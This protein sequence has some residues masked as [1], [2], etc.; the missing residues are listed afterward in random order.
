MVAVRDVTGRDG[1]RVFQI[2]RSPS[3]IELVLRKLPQKNGERQM[4]DSDGAT[5]KRQPAYSN[6]KHSPAAQAKRSAS[7][8]PAERC[9]H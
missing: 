6:H 1:K 9:G 8:E 4:N 2:F 3:Q 7:N 5:T